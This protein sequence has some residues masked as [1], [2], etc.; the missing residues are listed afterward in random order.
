MQHL[1]DDSPKEWYDA[2]LLYDENHIANEVF[3]SAL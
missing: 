1:S 2:A 3:M